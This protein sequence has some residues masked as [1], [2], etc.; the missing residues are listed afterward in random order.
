MKKSV[1]LMSAAF[2]LA[3]GSA[4]T[5]KLANPTGFYNTGSE[6]VSGETDNAGCQVQTNGSLCTIQFLGNPVSPVYETQAD[7]E[8]QTS[9]KILRHN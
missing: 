7:A 1:I 6:V 4:F 9:T 2:V 8:N 5:T 3:L